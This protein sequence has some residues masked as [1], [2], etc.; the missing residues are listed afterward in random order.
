MT[1]TEQ[2]QG[3][4]AADNILEFPE[5][6]RQAR[7]RHRRVWWISG[8]ALVTLLAVLSAVLYFSPVLAIT[9]VT[10]SGTELLA[11]GR[12]VELLQP[13][14]DRPLPQVGQRTVE[15]LLAGEPA[16]DTVRVQAEPPH[17]LS[18]EVVEHQ[19]V[20]MVHDGA[21][22]ILYSAAG[23]ALA[24]LPEDRAGAYHLP[25]VAS[26]EDVKD[27]EVFDAI[28]SV[29]GTLPESIRTL[30]ESASAETIDS[31]TLTLTDGRTVL[32]GNPEHGPRK[33]Q[34]LEALLKVPE[35]EEA[36]VREFDVSTPD[37]PVTR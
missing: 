34:V 21:D 22:R 36:P 15:D 8:A 10:V 24:T 14:R 28:T 19:P 20:A 27:P 37:R 29:L 33:A 2:Q 23:T 16:V 26:A 35:N 6:H 18:V 12:A 25:S 4:P 11:Q 5:T 13:V 30:M 17:G 31:V 7:R 9:T 1:E 3:A 32:W